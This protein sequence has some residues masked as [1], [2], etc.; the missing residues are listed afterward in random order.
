MVFSILLVGLILY[1]LFNIFKSQNEPQ[2]MIE[3]LISGDFNGENR[4]SGVYAYGPDLKTGSL[5][6]W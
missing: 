4:A 6:L 1:S 5:E 3:G 2:P